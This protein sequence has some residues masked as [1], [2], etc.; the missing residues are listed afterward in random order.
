MSDLR[1]FAGLALCALL[2]CGTEQPMSEGE[3]HW[4]VSCSSDADCGDECLVCE[5]GACTRACSRDDQCQGP[6]AGTCFDRGS[7]L[8]LQRC[9]GSIPV[10][11]GVCLPS[12]ADAECGQGQECLSGGCVPLADAPGADS[13][14]Q[15]GPQTPGD[16][17]AIDW[18]TPLWVPPLAPSI[19]GADGRLDGTWVVEGCQVDDMAGG[20][21]RFEIE[22]QADGT[23]EGNVVFGVPEYDPG[24]IWKPMAFDGQRPPVAAPSVGYPGEGAP[25]QYGR[26]AQEVLGDFPYRM[27][28]GRLAADE[29]TFVVSTRDLWH[30]WCSMQTTYAWSVGERPFWTCVPQDETQWVDVDPGKLE[31]CAPN[32]SE[33]WDCAGACPQPLCRCDADGCDADTYAAQ[34]SFWVQLSAG[35]MMAQWRTATSYTSELLLKVE[36]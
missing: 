23:Y 20:C 25:D 24:R 33:G 8:L 27:L 29:L 34:T 35:R 13:G 7:P 6:Q 31:L 12:C 15:E 19:E 21:V 3:T 17:G 16:A 14:A 9:Q 18:S 11:A 1:L 26:L 32:S 10:S 22:R 36:P 5:C 28:G 4:L 30:E 2:G